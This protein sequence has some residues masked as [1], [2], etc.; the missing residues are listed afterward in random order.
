MST[1]S[2]FVMQQTNQK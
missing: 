2:H 1:H